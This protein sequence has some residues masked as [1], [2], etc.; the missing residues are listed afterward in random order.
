VELLIHIG[1]GKTGSSFLQSSFRVHRGE[2]R[3]AGVDYPVGSEGKWESAADRGRGNGLHLLQSE[4][5]FRRLLSLNP[6]RQVCAQL[7]S[8]EILFEEMDRAESLS[9][10]P[11]TAARLGFE[12][13][14]VFLAI[15][16]PL[17]HAAS[18]WQEEIKCGRNSDLEQKLLTFDFP[19]RV[20]ALLSKLSAVP[21]LEI[22][23]RNFSRHRTHWL[24]IMEEWIGLPPS[25]LPELSVPI[26]NRSLT[27]GE[28][29]LMRA[30]NGSG[31]Y[32]RGFTN[33]LCQRLPHIEA[34][35]VRPSLAVQRA[36]LERINPAIER[37]NARIPETEHYCPDLRE[38][39]SDPEV[40]TLTPEQIDVIGETLGGEISALRSAVA[41]ERASPCAR[42]RRFARSA[43]LRLRGKARNRG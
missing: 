41:R 6:A 37:V 31:G 38:S 39:K 23:V 21:R 20:D 15:R 32:F 7:W 8:S 29:A 34:D 24:K 16:D 26:V 27:L 28:L 22:T 30:L 12:K 25:T 9:F 14:R 19:E 4:E 3:S 10:L 36:A 1:H 42:A 40:F 2:L 17:G 11:E 5:N 18:D 33:S 13:V 43:V 35:Q